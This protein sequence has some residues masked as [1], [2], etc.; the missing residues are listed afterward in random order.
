MQDRD[1]TLPKPQE[2]S[3]SR[4]LE[5]AIS[6]FSRRGYEGV[7]I[8]DIGRQAGVTAQLIYH[9]FSTGKRGLY[10]EA[11]LHA[12][13]HLMELSVQ[14]MPPDPDP[15]DPQ[16][17]MI[18]VEGVATFIRNVATAAGNAEDPRETEMVHLAY[19]ETFDLPEDLKREIMEE[20]W[21]SVSRIRGFLLILLPDIS[22]LSL[23][24]TA[25]AITGPLYHER[26]ITGVQAELR[27]GVTIPADR[28]A[29]FY[30]AYALR[31]LG[32]DRELPASHRYST[33]N[34]DRV[35]NS[36]T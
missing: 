14:G 15:T 19:R 22:P 29:D 20:I 33:Q 17:R 27:K 16:A 32:I 36:L 6:L 9:Y 10:R 12:L 8:H 5:A 7:S 31:F 11:Y 35:L 24:L 25:T 34:L 13:H 1:A 21:I 26:M 28:K 30:V 18:A 3:R 4:L 2:N 23:S